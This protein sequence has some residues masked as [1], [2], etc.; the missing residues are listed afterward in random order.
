MATITEVSLNI[1]NG[2]TPSTK[3]VTI[4]Y[5]INFADG[6]AG[7][8]YRLSIDLFGYDGSNDPNNEQAPKP[9]VLLARI[10]FATAFPGVTSFY[11]SIT[12]QPGLYSPSPIVR[13]F[14]TATLDEDP[15]EWEGDSDTIPPTLP[16]PVQQTDEAYAVVTLTASIKQSAVYEYK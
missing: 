5:K 1:T 3:K 13:E 8:K 6:E 12:A 14:P 15:V 10:P 7:L 2:T 16:F 9:P 11:K 4:G